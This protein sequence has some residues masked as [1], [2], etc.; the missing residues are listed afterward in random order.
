MVN[1]LSRN[2]FV[3]KID[4]DD[5]III[6]VKRPKQIGILEEESSDYVIL[7]DLSEIKTRDDLLAFKQDNKEYF[8]T[9]V[10]FN[11]EEIIEQNDLESAL[12]KIEKAAKYNPKNAERSEADLISEDNNKRMSKAR[13]PKMNG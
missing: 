10:K 11:S 13:K 4:I 12:N 3:N 8:I 1:K 7:G 2:E 6:G 5:K 9:T